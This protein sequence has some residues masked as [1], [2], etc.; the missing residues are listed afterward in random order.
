M[1]MNSS[2]NFDIRISSYFAHEAKRLSKHYPS[3]KNDYNEFLKSLKEDPYQGDDLG[4]GVRKVRM[5][6]TSKGKGKSGGAR[7]ITL[8]ILINEENM[9]IN[10]LLLYD[11]QVADN[12]NPLALKD[13]LKLRSIS[14]HQEPNS[15]KNSVTASTEKKKQNDL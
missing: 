9:E 11:K 3:F 1:R 13:A 4:N 6:I 14:M 15:I 12:F 8:N 2:M 10:L 7:V 5:A